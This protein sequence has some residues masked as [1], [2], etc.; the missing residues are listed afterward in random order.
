MTRK[1]NL[2]NRRRTW[3]G[4]PEPGWRSRALAE[5]PSVWAVISAMRWRQ[6]TKSGRR[7]HP[8]FAPRDAQVGGCGR[9]EGAF[10]VPAHHPAD[11]GEH[12]RG[13]ADGVERGIEPDRRRPDLGV[14]HQRT[15]TRRFEPGFL[16]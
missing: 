3:N 16:R 2:S 8:S 15:A 9:P 1:A 4:G 6:S 11:R 10:R 7:E 13:I 14:H 5:R 12:L